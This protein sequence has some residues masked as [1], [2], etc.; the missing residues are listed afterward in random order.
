MLDHQLTHGTTPL[1]W[2][3]PGVP[4]ATN[5]DD[6]PDYGRCIQNMPNEFYGGIETDKVAELGVGY[7][8]F[9]KFTGERK[10]LEASLRCADALARFVR[11]GDEEH[12]PWPFR[13][14]ART[15]VT[16]AGEEYGGNVVASVRL[17]DELLKLKVGDRENYTKARI[18][19]WKWLLDYPLSSSS[20]AWDK[21]SGYFEDVSKNTENVNQMSP[22][23]VSYYL[24]TRDDPASVDKNWSGHVGHL[25]D[26]IRKRFGRGPYFGAWAIDEQG[27]PDG[28]G[29]CSRSGL[30]SHTSRWA[31]VN[32]L[33][34]ERTGDAQAREDAIR[35][36]NYATYFAGSDGR[37][38][39]CGKDFGGQYWFSDGYSDYLRHFNWAMGAIPE[40]AP[41]GQNHLLRSSSV[42]QKVSYSERRLEYRTYDVAAKEVLRLNFKPRSAHAG[43]AVL[44]ERQ[45]GQQEGYT[46]QSL[47][48]GDYVIRIN[49]AN[50]GEIT[51]LGATQ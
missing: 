15:G 27:T 29:C 14:D 19:A 45:D 11:P 38:S 50:S 46:L 49:H 48:S 36:L 39:C 10:Y 16:L 37:I 3:W 40:L 17:F 1:D 2:K 51:I 4:F 35:S 20:R 18:A 30:S 13:L 22:T 21:W 7:A 42:V 43:S 26:W 34:Y 47:G 31:A 25:I 28:R 9:Y 32:A 24:L 8:L 33:Y 6:Q 12:T 5:C 44:Q 41:T 23:M